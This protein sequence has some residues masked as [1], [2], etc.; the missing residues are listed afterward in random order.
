MKQPNDYA[1]VIGIDDYPGYR[2]LKG[3]ISDAQEFAEWLCDDT[4]GGGLPSDNCKTVYS[5]PDPLI[6]L[7]AQVDEAFVGV[8]SAIP[9]GKLARRLYVYFSGHGT[10]ESNLITNM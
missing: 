1:I 6:P 3:A 2:P 9:K 10:A 4:Q 8:F 5:T 7:Q